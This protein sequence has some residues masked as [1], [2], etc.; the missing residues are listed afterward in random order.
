[1]LMCDRQIRIDSSHELLVRL[2]DVL[3]PPSGKALFVEAYF[4]E[5]GTHDGSPLMCVAGYL[6]TSE[7]CR[8]FDQEWSEVLREFD[9]PYFRMSEC[10][11]AT[12]VF[13]GRSDICDTVARKMI[14][15]I[16]R[17]IEYGVVSSVSEADFQEVCSPF[18]KDM[19]GQAY[20]WCI[21][22]VMVALREWCIKYN[23]NAPISYFF[24]AGH[25][26]QQIAVGAL[27]RLVEV[28]EFGKLYRYGS[29]TFS[30]KQ[31]TDPNQPVLRP[32]QA[33][34]LLAWQYRTHKIRHAQGK[35][36][37]LDLRSLFQAPHAELSYDKQELR[38]FM[39]T[40]VDYPEEPDPHY[41]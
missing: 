6:F 13:R 17:R 24:E 37:R 21:H 16:K 11:H 8:R 25:R 40:C 4:D 14:G 3:L 20:G 39:R 7:Q 29:H 15:I 34:D 41:D 27:N 5:S 12:G 31:S 19:A 1:M 23:Q 30:A 36:A 18:V 32:L 28:P 26:H 35:T 22:K 10:A 38:E 33:A 2:L 9:L